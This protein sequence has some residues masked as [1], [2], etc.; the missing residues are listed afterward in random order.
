MLKKQYSVAKVNL[1]MA[2]HYLYSAVETLQQI[3][4]APHL[5]ELED[6]RLLTLFIDQRDESA[7]A[8][9]V[10]RHGSMVLAVCRRVLQNDHAAEGPPPAL[11]RLVTWSLSDPSAAHHDPVLDAATA[12]S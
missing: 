11:S 1:Q 3:A 10:Q 6:S 5:A 2:K 12:A 8:T 9:I 7:F 4:G